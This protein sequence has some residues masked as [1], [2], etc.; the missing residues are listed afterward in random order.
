MVKPLDSPYIELKPQV[1]LQR[2]FTLKKRSKLGL[3][4]G[5]EHKVIVNGGQVNI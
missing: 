1:P 2:L 5:Q 4:Q 3:E